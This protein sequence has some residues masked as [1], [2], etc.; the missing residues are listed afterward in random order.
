MTHVPLLRRPF[1]YAGLNV[2]LWL[3][4]ANI[5][6]FALTYVYPELG[7]HLA[8]RP[9][10]VAGGAV[11]QLFTYMFVHAGLS[12]LFVNMLGLFFFGTQ[13]ERETGSWE[14]LFY[15]LVTGTLA[16]LFSFFVYLATGGWNI[17]LAGSSGA[18]FAVLL[19]FATI[20][21]DARIY[22]WAILPVRAPLL[23]LA[24]T[25]IELVSQFS[26]SR[27]SIAHVTHLAGFGFGFL[28]FLVRFGT[29]PLR[30]FFPGR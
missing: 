24:Y 7:Y 3:I 14:F 26:G 20:F 23:V 11:W 27:A 30:R 10:A 16:G 22:V 12:H 25:G 18:V 1:R 15:Y 5:L 6:V 21:P 28:Y 13:V 9:R 19:A 17:M 29:N 8:M 2:S 4:A